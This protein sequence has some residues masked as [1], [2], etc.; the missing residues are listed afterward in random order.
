[1][2][3]NFRVEFEFDAFESFLPTNSKKKKDARR[4]PSSSFFSLL[5]LFFFQFLLNNNKKYTVR[6]ALGPD[7][8]LLVP[9]P[10]LSRQDRERDVFFFDIVIVVIT[11]S[12]FSQ[13]RPP[14][15]RPVAE[16]GALLLGG[17][18]FSGREAAHRVRARRPAAVGDG[19]RDRGTSGDDRDAAPERGARE[20]CLEFELFFFVV[21]QRQRRP[22]P[23]E[24]ALRR[25]GRARRPLDG[26]DDDGAE[27]GAELDREGRGRRQEY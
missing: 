13:R 20:A 7:A 22:P 6:H 14:Q 4:E 19:V 1:M 26:E 9:L 24:P 27:V 5:I 16:A 11:R 25:R 17:A 21:K 15:P 12:S 18:A 3:L 23:V 2:D 10:D 8:R